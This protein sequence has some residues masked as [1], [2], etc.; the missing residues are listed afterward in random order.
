MKK[1]FVAAII[2]MIVFGAL[3]ILSGIYADR[4]LDPYVHSL[5]EQ[6]KPMKHR[7]EYKKI[8]VN[9]FRQYI[10]VRDVKM[11]PAPELNK[12]ENVWM[13][14][15]VSTIRLTDIDIR[16]L[17]FD[18]ALI[19]GDINIL[20][21]DVIVHLPL[22]PPEEIID[23]VQVDKTKKARKQ[24]LKSIS[25][26]RILI[27]GGSFK[28]IRNN[29]ILASSPEISF[30]TEN[31]NII[32]NSEDEAIG[33]TYGNMKIHLGDIKLYS[34]SGLYDM[35]VAGFTAN[36]KDSTITLDGFRMIPKYDKKEFSGK[37]Q[38]QDDRFDISIGKIELARIGIEQL[39]FGGPLRIS[40]IKI[41]NL[42]ADIYRD[43]NVAF[44]INKFPLFHNEMFLKLGLP[45]Y[46]D[47][48]AII[49]SRIEYGE[50]VA[51][52]PEPGSIILEN[53]NLKTLN[54]TNQIGTDTSFNVMLLT[55][56]AK[57]MGEG[58]LNAELILPLEG[59]T[60]TIECSGSVGAMNLAPLNSMLE[61]SINMKFHAGRLNR[62]TFAFTGNDNQSSGWMEF[63]Y[64]DLDV[65]LL[66]KEP[67]KEWG[68]VSVLANTMT[69]SNN[70][71]PGKDL[72]IVSIGFERD[73]NKGLINYVWKTI[74]SGMVHTILPIKKYQINRKSADKDRSDKAAK[75]ED[76][77]GKQKKKKK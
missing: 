63:L 42:S 77:G 41:D 14:I 76:T 2:L 66:K 34:E 21:P 70:P 43:K 29:V 53:F 17:F 18:K 16:A 6:N 37:L 65:I 13:E 25:L 36:K 10:K 35:S 5:L 19:I 67:E 58:T 27:S 59:D 51:G 8:K 31:I 50:L 23:S 40:A 46:L 49:N 12:E 30:I 48:L 7:I 60:R 75:E 69:L 73:K 24:A 9:L 62:M 55:V 74:Q 26:E 4:I 56:N 39:I 33:Y 44:N 1:L 71:A 68:F 52:R 57:V 11:T 47:T 64:Q 45:F 72:K 3:L 22:N 15:N 32:K 20:Q 54:L 28:L 38:F 61:P